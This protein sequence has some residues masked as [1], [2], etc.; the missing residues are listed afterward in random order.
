[1]LTVDDFSTTANFSLRF[2]LS[3]FAAIFPGGPGLA[4]IRISQFWI[5][6]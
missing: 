4:G 6:F 2:S 3:V 1:L 5:L